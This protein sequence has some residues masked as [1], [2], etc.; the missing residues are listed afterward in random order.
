M[1]KASKRHAEYYLQAATRLDSK[2]FEKKWP[3]IALAARW[4]RSP[5]TNFD[6]ALKFIFTLNP[7]L[8]QF[9]HWNDGLSWNHYAH[10]LALRRRAADAKLEATVNMAWFSNAL[11]RRQLAR[12]YL[13]EAL[14]LARRLKKNASQASIL[15]SLGA[16]DLYMG[17]FG[18]GR[19]YLKKALQIRRGLRDNYGSALVLNNL[20][21]SRLMRFEPNQAL[22]LLEEAKR[23]LGKNRDENYSLVM[24][25]LAS[26]HFALHLFDKAQEYFDE[27][28]EIRIASSDLVGELSTRNNLA[29]L[30]LRRKKFGAALAEFHRALLAARALG[31]K[32]GEAI[33]L[34]NIGYLYLE[35]EDFSK[36]GQSYKSALAIAKAIG[37]A[38]V[39]KTAQNGLKSLQTNAMGDR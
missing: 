30:L 14:V 34:N 37:E 21:E 13:K 27:A 25:N 2:Q 11:G 28:L 23:L 16:I 29:I 18:T 12:Q 35:L 32:R 26:V 9:G 24:N 6:F 3:Q 8:I 20:A 36:A 33:A 10:K 31:Q 38:S 5:E 7:V 15:N 19:A 1:S 22:P 17:Q 4:V 39:A